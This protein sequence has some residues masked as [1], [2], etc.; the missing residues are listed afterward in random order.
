MERFVNKVINATFCVVISLIF[1][2]ILFFQW[3]EYSCKNQYIL[4]NMQIL[5]LL[6]AL[7]VVCSFIYYAHIKRKGCVQHNKTVDYDKMAFFFAI[8]LFLGQVYVFYNIFFL[9]GWDAGVLRDSASQLAL[10]NNGTILSAEHYYS[11]YPNN[12]FLTYMSALILKINNDIGVFVGNYAM[13]SCVL[14]NCVLNSSACYLVYKTAKLFVD[15]KLAFVGFCIV[16]MSIGL[17]PWSVIFYS[18]S[19][20][21]IIPILTFYLYIKPV[22]NKLQKCLCR[23]VSVMVA[24][25][26]YFIKPQCV[27][28]LIA[29][30]VI[31]MVCLLNHFKP[32][33]LLR[34]VALMVTCV[35]LYLIVSFSVEWCTE[36]VGLTLDDNKTFGVTHFLMMGAN[37]TSGGVY[38]QSDVD[39]S[40]SFATVQD[41]TNANIEE[42]IERLKDM[43]IIGYIKH[44]GRKMLTTFNDGT[45][46]WNKEGSFYAMI[47]E[48]LNSKMTT[49]LKSFYY[50]DGARHQY[51]L[52]FEQIVWMI[53]MI[54]ALISCFYKKRGMNILWLSVLGLVFYEVL[55]EARARYIY[56]FVPILCLLAVCGIDVVV[57]Y[58]KSKIDWMISKKGV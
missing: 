24:I 56:I 8:L 44:I 33:K 27:F 21:V 47:P 25:V 45:F 42:T 13:M 23:F 38:S 19:V 28:V 6:I 52:L 14:V 35:F 32:A 58:I 39:F 49:F 31:E 37:E 53:I 57:K 12:L 40:Q 2:I 22:S 26:G 20:G 1:F 50:G 29:I 30:V 16:V 46:A 55:F 11:T 34:F 5:G 3:T 4:S 9:T 10:G 7:F 48:A 15:K 36:K 54:F 51:F 18:D 41:R 43:G 17:S